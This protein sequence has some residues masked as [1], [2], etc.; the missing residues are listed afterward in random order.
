MLAGNT[1]G[2]FIESSKYISPSCQSCNAFPL[3]KGGCR[4]DREPFIC[5]KPALNRHCP[6]LKVFFEYAAP[7]LKTLAGML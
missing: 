6:G 3:C 7:K 2:D 5:G 1:A 4:R